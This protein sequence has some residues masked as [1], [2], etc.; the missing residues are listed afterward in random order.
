[1]RRG[2]EV[3]ELHALRPVCA[4]FPLLRR[5]EAG[6]ASRC[7]AAGGQ[8]CPGENIPHRS[9]VRAAAPA[10]PPNIQPCRDGALWC[11]HVPGG[12][13]LARQTAALCTVSHDTAVGSRWRHLWQIRG[14]SGCL[15][16]G[17]VDGSSRHESAAWWCGASAQVSRLRCEPDVSR[18]SARAAWL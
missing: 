9:R 2:A 11:C 7:D 15:G 6:I 10:I 1:M 4:R 5:G 17:G 14:L 3:F 13:A 18:L 12:S 8:E 16:C